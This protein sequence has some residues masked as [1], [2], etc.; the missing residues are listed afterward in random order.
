MPC[1]CIVWFV[2]DYIIIMVEFLSGKGEVGYLKRW[3]GSY[4]SIVSGLVVVMAT[5]VCLE[6]CVCVGS[7]VALSY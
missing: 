1:I 6:C 3:G 5:L 4:V 7:Y 2:C